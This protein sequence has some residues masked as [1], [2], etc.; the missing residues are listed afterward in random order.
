[1]RSDRLTYAL[2]QDVAT[3]R[4][5]DLQSYRYISAAMF[6]ADAVDKRA[7]R[8]WITSG[9]PVTVDHLQLLNTTQSVREYQ[10]DNRCAWHT[11]MRRVAESA[12]P[13]WQTVI[14]MRIEKTPHTK[15]NHD[16]TV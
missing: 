16:G 8:R 2:A 9:G 11:I 3:A 5:G 6:V 1:M 7:A 13:A 14:G 10:R 15:E 12:L 4:Y